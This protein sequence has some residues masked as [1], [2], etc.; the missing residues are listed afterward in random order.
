MS[1]QANCVACDESPGPISM[2]SS[3]LVS[4]MFTDVTG[5]KVQLHYTI[6]RSCQSELK[7]CYNFKKR[8]HEIFILYD[9]G[10][11]PNQPKETPQRHQQPFEEKIFANPLDSTE[12]TIVKNEFEPNRSAVSYKDDDSHQD[13][14]YQ[15]DNP[16]DE[17]FEGTHDDDFGQYEDINPPMSDDDESTTNDNDP[18]FEN[19]SARFECD[20]CSKAFSKR[21]RL[22]AHKAEHRNE[23]LYSCPRPGCN[24]AFNVPHRLTR[25]LRNVHDADEEEINESTFA[26]VEDSEGVYVVRS[27]WMFTKDGNQH[28]YY[29]PASLQQ[30]EHFA[31]FF[32]KPG[33]DWVQY[34]V[35][36]LR[37]KIPS[38]ELTKR[39]QNMRLQKRNLKTDSGPQAKKTRLSS[40]FNSSQP[41]S[42]NFMP[43]FSF[44]NRQFGAQMGY[45]KQ[46][47]QQRSF[48]PQSQ[49]NIQPL[50]TEKMKQM[51]SN[52]NTQLRDLKK[53][54][55]Y[56]MHMVQGRSS[57]ASL[58]QN[59]LEEDSLSPKAISCEQE[60]TEMEA[61]LIEYDRNPLISSEFS[62]KRERMIEHYAAKIKNISKRTNPKIGLVGSLLNLY[63]APEFLNTIGWTNVQGRL[64]IKDM[65]GHISLFYEIVNRNT[66]NTYLN[67]EESSIALYT[68]LRR[69]HESKNA[70]HRVKDKDGDVY[71]NMCDENSLRISSSSGYRPNNDFFM[72]MEPQF[73][74]PRVVQERDIQEHYG[75]DVNE[76]T[77]DIEN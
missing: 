66:P 36:I 5:L 16:D 24:S 33:D 45:S 62:I 10:S 11:I 68:F 41:H 22:V 32:N 9:S 35:K 55:N 51:E 47:L 39:L 43:S 18:D 17:D 77:Q 12:I 61:N 71:K 2:P 70:K 3:G 30:P 63:F 46:N 50:Q 26:L 20:E 15:E 54:L 74:M 27:S 48:H 58:I 49:M 1:N 40:D 53:K 72:K 29:P 67:M 37:Q 65:V 64:A 8:C 52:F 42:S 25:H 21:S 38:Y 69:F 6:C 76:D 57:G 73:D 60:L 31:K 28:I 59:T 7:A 34:Q 44:N 14:D 75:R 23:R 19:S 4:K 56:L 13:D